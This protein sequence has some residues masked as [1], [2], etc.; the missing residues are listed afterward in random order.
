MWI[1]GRPIGTS[2]NP[3]IPYRIPALGLR[4]G[5]RS[6][7]VIRVDNRRPATLREGWWNH[8]GLTR[9]AELVPRAPLA[10]ENHALLPDV[11]C[12]SGGACTASVLLD[13]RLVNR[14]PEAL[15]AKIDVQLT[16]PSGRTTHGEVTPAPL[17]GPSFRREQLRIPIEAPEL[18]S[19]GSPQRYRYTLAV[20]VAGIPVTVQEGMVGLRSVRVVGGRLRLNGR[21]L[22]LRGAGITEDM[23]GRGSALRDQDIDQIVRDLQSLNAN[24][25]RAHYLLDP[26][27]LDRLDAA[28]IMVWSEAAVYHAD[29][30]LRT[31]QGRARMLQTLRGT[32]REARKHP[33]VLTHAVGDEFAQEPDRTPGTREYLRRAAETVR[34]LDPSVPPSIALLS[35]PN[36]PRQRAYDAFP[37]LGLNTYYGWYL[38]KP[39]IRSTA[40]LAD[41]RPYLDSMR[42]KYP[43]HA[44]AIA[45]FGAEARFSGPRTQKGTYAFQ[46]DYVGKVLDVVDSYP[47]LAGAIYW[48][49]REFLVKPDWTGGAARDRKKR[50]PIHA[51]GLIH[52]DG[53]PK[54]AW[55]V[56]RERFGAVQVLR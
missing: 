46:A 51:K 34:D 21:L 20:S 54:P 13:G 2:R 39:G 30:E 7:V 19:P 52:Y 16:S 37:L 36:I 10:L 53:R 55:D 3:Y 25:T 35:Y 22:A 4:P 43:G 41:L 40:N 31:R 17:A 6:L 15:Q 56:A 27:L 50:S 8:G 32:V 18:W 12:D 23:P 28:G 5:Q 47:F 24:V 48:T 9:P 11:Q 14:T 44:L 26:R 29:E 38:G 49:A 33:S 42:R 1:D 45:E